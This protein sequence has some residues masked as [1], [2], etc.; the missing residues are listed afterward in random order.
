MKTAWIHTNIC[1]GFCEVRLNQSKRMP[2]SPEKL[3]SARALEECYAV[4]LV[5]QAWDLRLCYSGTSFRLLF[6]RLYI[7]R[8]KT[9]NEHRKIFFEVS[10]MRGLHRNK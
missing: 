5:K 6:E 2:R 1:F 10:K 3:L 7:R 9:A 8:M 4:I